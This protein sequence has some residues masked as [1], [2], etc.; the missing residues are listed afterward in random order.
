LLTPPLEPKC[1]PTY[2]PP[3]LNDPKRLLY[4]AATFW[5]YSVLQ[6]LPHSR[7]LTYMTLESRAHVGFL[8]HTCP[9]EV[10]LTAAYKDGEQPILCELLSAPSWPFLLFAI[11]LSIFFPFFFSIF[12][13]MSMC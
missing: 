1:A 11:F 3:S 5:F 10:L 12:L 7:I 13:I 6:D 4:L 2:L 9:R 8:R